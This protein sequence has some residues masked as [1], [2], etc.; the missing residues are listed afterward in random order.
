MFQKCHNYGD[1]LLFIIINIVLFD[2]CNFVLYNRNPNLDSFGQYIQC[3]KIVDTSS[4]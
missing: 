3:I 4:E 1:I 2:N